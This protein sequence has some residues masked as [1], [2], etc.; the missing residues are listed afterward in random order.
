MGW[1]IK[2]FSVTVLFAASPSYGDS[3]IP[4]TRTSYFSPDKATRF[5]VI[6][7][8]L[9]D[10][11]SYFS[12]KVDGKE[13]AGQRLGGAPRA[14]GI[15]ERRSGTVWTTIWRAPLV[16]DVAPVRA[17]VTNGGGHVVTFD[18]W[19]S[20][21]FGDNVVAIYRG[22]GT[23][24]RSMKLTDILPEDY[25]RALPTTVSSRWWGGEHVLSRNGQQVVLKVVVPSG[26]GSIGSPPRGYVDVSV[27]LATGA[28]AP[29][30]NAAWTRAMAAAA[31]LAARSKA[32]EA[33][34]RA[35]LIAPLSP[36]SST[37]ND[38]WNRYMYQAVRRLAPQ[39]PQRGFDPVWILPASG[40]PEYAD[41]SKAI[42]EVFAEWDEKSDLAFASPTN[43]AALARMLAESA[44]AAPAGRL[45]GSRLFVA[46]PPAF[47][48]GVSD[49]LSRTGAAV[50]IFDPAVPIPQR[51]EELRKI[52]IAPEQAQAESAR[53]TA[54]ARRFEAD[55]MRLDKLAPPELKTAA[56]DTEEMEVMADHLE[57]EADKATA[58]VGHNPKSN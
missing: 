24:L 16:N 22:D 8:E 56:T 45:T 39:G 49:A 11:L 14:L 31:P 34:W 20:V 29:L 12:D 52:G 51:P 46:L 57:V 42:R 44:Q 48:S 38:E 1:L 58:P 19:H 43:P 7:R 25:V 27:D 5:T 26:S 17:L 9:A 2:V 18:N 23:L 36:P 21:G 30:A 53:A 35:G 47:A 28:V 4:A 55:A 15:L 10:R 40:T 54:D 37:A 50:I 3:W 32:E 6:P 13:A 33:A 41:R